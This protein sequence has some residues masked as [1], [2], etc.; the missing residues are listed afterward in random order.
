MIVDNRNLE[1]A[2]LIKMTV[3]DLMEEMELFLIA[4]ASGVNN[5]VHN[6]YI[7]D[8]LSWVMGNADQKCVWITVQSHVNIIAVAA[9]IGASCV[10]V[11]EGVFVERD[12]VEKAND[13]GIPIFASSYNSYVLAK[14]L[15]KLGL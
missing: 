3:R 5:E 4:G 11:S 6:V 10:I 1:R 12:T 9:L 14:Q 8:L 7:G 15:V 2:E 13:E